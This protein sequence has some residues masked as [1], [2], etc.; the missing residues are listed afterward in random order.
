METNV[1]YNAMISDVISLPLKTLGFTKLHN[2]FYYPYKD[3]LGIMNFQKSN[4]SNSKEIIFTLNAGI[5]SKRIQNFLGQVSQNKKPDIW[6]AHWR[7]RI[8]N[9]L[10]EKND[11]W[12]TITKGT[13]IEELGNT[14]LSMVK[15]Y[16]F[17][18]ILEFISDEALRDLWLSSKSPSLTEFD[19]LLYLAVLLK[20]IGPLENLDTTIK[21][22]KEVTKNKPSAITA[23][24]FIEKLM[25][26]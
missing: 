4:K 14:I 11:V 3:N 23:A 18:A 1:L 10:P 17:P 2:T 19:R 20:Q 7:V 25:V 9:L 13:N 22:L 5:W 8:G 12:W 21:K 6:D 26:N 16:V 24:V 15:D